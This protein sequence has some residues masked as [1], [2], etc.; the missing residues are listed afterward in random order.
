MGSTLAR[1]LLAL[2]AAGAQAGIHRIRY[3]FA[4]AAPALS[5]RLA[6]GEGWCQRWPTGLLLNRARI[7]LDLPR[8]SRH[9]NTLGKTRIARGKLAASPVAFALESDPEVRTSPTLPISGTSPRNFACGTA[10]TSAALTGGVVRSGALGARGAVHFRL[11]LASPFIHG[12]QAMVQT[13]G[14]GTDGGSH[15]APARTPRQARH[16]R[17]RCLRTSSAAT[18]MPSGIMPDQAR[19]W[20]SLNRWAEAGAYVMFRRLDRYR[21]DVSWILACANRLRGW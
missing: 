10:S 18:I 12:P 14:E 19:H 11:L 6:A 4:R 21:Q 8:P 2:R 16:H 5:V 9:G 15:Y 20:P 1:S 3:S 7:A 17:R 13:P